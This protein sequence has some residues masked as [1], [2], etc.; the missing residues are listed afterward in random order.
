MTSRRTC[1]RTSGSL[2]TATSSGPEQHGRTRQQPDER[3]VRPDVREAP[4]TDAAA[5]GGDEDAQQD[6][7]R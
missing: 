4:G 5:R 1:S 6:A 3:R 7:E 2:G